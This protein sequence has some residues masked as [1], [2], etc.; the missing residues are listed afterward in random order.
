[1][2]AAVKDYTYDGYSEQDFR[3]DIDEI[4]LKIKPLYVQLYTYVRRVLATK[5]KGH[6][7][8]YGRLPTHVLGNVTIQNIGVD[9][10]PMNF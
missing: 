1:M 4:W 7:K 8:L 6:V 5:Y 2:L 3:S 9:Q 10:C